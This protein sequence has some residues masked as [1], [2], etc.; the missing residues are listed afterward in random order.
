MD[1]FGYGAVHKQT[2][3]FRYEPGTGYYITRPEDGLDFGLIMLNRLQ[4]LAFEANHLVAISRKNW[5]RQSELTFDFYKML[6]IP[7]DNVIRAGDG[8]DDVCVRPMMIHVNKINI[9]DLEDAPS[10][11]EAPPT[12]AWFIG[13]I[14]AECTIKGLK[15]M[16][17]GPIY[18]FRRD[19][20][21][22]LT[23]HVVA[24]QS[25]WWYK[26]RTVFGCSVPLFAED[27]YQQL[28]ELIRGSKKR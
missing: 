14:P 9:D 15:G 28:G 13:K 5:E 4:V 20:Q 3:P 18:G 24:L 7:V 22:H 2:V 21:G 19:D 17:G 16:S 1:Y 11:A 10:D 8:S 25:R 12:N 27:T 26:S 23:Y 6:G